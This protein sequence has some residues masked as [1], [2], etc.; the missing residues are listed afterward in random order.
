MKI[1]FI[2]NDTELISKFK[3][4]ECFE[5]FKISSE[6]SD[7]LDVDVL[8]ISDRLVDINLLLESLEKNLLNINF[9]FYMVSNE[10]F[11]N[12]LNNV[13]E[14]NK[15]IMIPPKKTILQIV[16]IVCTHTLKEIDSHNNIIVF[17]G[18]DEK[19]GTTQ[20]AQSVAERLA[21]K[22]SLKIFLGFLNGKPSLDYIENDT[23]FSLDTLKIKIINQILDRNELLDVCIKKD[24]LYILKGVNSILDKRHYHPEH[25]EYL[26]KLIS[27][28]F[29]VVI[30]DAGSDIEL[31]MTIGALNTT[32]YRYLVTTQQEIAFNNYKRIKSQVLNRFDI[33]DYMI[34]VNKFI[35]SERLNT[36]Y[37]IA[38]LYEGTLASSVPY[39]S[40]SWQS[41]QERK[42]LLH[43]NDQ[44]F[45]NSIDKIITLISTQINFDYQIQKKEDKG[46]LNRIRLKLIK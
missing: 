37:H 40:W 5:D 44:E 1:C 43:F 4:I 22:T 30:I 25:I 34:I 11:N 28:E 45:I 16:E 13:L 26:L 42:S 38:K 46:F 10:N 31:G 7:D 14:A 8:I 17:F 23:N 33:K 21:Q 19:V 35:E 9:I 29:D 12:T 15:I 6:L 36:Q 24:N 41:E 2:S 27:K 3:K 39:L 32:Q 20:I 18:A